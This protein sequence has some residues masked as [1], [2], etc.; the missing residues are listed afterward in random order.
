MTQPLPTAT[1]WGNFLLGRGGAGELHV[2]PAGHD[3]DPSPIGRSLTALH[4]PDHRIARPAIRLGY[5]RD[6]EKS[7]TSHRGREPFV[8]VDWDEALDITAGALRSTQQRAGNRAIYGGSY[9]WASA[10]RFHHTQ[11][12]IHRFLRMFGG[13]TASVDTYSFAAAEVTIPHVLGMNAYFAARQSPTTE[14]IAQHCARIVFFG[15]A[16]ARNAQVNPG[17]Y[18]A[19][20]YRDHLATLRA[21]G[22]DTVNIGPVRDDLDPALA[23]R[24]IPCRPGTDTAIMLAI[25][26]TLVVEDLHDRAF[27]DRYTTGFDRFADYVTGRADGE[28]KTPEWAATLSEV[29][30]HEIRDLARLLARERCVIGLPY[31][32]QRAEHG[33]QT[34]WA[35][36][37]LAA[38]LGYIGLPGGGVLMG[39]GV[40]MTNAMQRRYLP[41]EIPALPQ[42]TN[43]VS[44]VVPVARLTEMLEHPGETVDYNGR[45]L[46]YPEIDLI[47]WAGGNPFHHH[48]DLNRLRRAWARP[49]TVVV[50]E[51]SW[52]STARLADIVL[53]STAA[54]EREDFAASRTDH[55]LS[56]MLP[57]LRPYGR[58]RDD[59]AIFADLAE[60]LGFGQRFT[61]GRTARQWVQHL[62]QTT[63][64]N[65]AAAGIT[66]PG[67]T[68]FRSGQPIDLRPVLPE[69]RHVLERFRDDPDCHPLA[70]PSGR[71]EIFSGT[72]ADFGY[73]DAPG[74]PAWFPA[75]EWLGSP[76]AQR[77]PLHL[78]SHQPATRLHSQ[79]DY[80]VTSRESKIRDREPLRMHPAD[81]ATRD[82]RDGDIVRVFNDRGAL[83]AGLR[84]TDAVRPGVVHMAT[85]AW[86]DPLDPAAP[87]SLDVHGNPNTVTNDIGTSSLAQGP[88][89]NSCLVEIERYD[90]ELPPLRIHKPPELITAEKLRAHP[91]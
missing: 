72:V 20:R 53:P 65:A 78:L 8:E 1:H 10:G 49:R 77:F 5:Y 2:T 56:P 41:F 14:E 32:L 45:V 35:A 73:P 47:Y 75:R 31:A 46:T 37:A 58:A 68:E 21:A 76:R 74:H 36:W 24:W 11:G 3:P 48:Q 4:D 86:Y 34:Y 19:H 38:A 6:R 23:A 17:G 64:D 28:P 62:W 16:A 27:L 26:H 69:S 7:D 30:A 71:I 80:G 88:S 67:Y 12:Q 42:P 85:G 82:L 40:G 50:N 18:G 15:G 61:E 9:G 43:P 84:L 22:V 87:D 60:R 91:G 59:Y 25:V 81:A 63:A 52:T 83:L 29:P 54:Q 39:T 66:L 70:T 90:D 44:D 89:V 51:I 13:Y 79:L 57:A 33:E 55:W